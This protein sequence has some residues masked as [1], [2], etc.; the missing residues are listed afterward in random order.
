ME[1]IPNYTKLRIPLALNYYTKIN[2]KD[3]LERESF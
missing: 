2:Y 1:N 3:S